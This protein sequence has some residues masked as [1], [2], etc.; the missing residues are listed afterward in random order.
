MN[1]HILQKKKVKKFFEFIKKDTT[2]KVLYTLAM[3]FIF[4]LG[5]NI[6][7]SSVDSTFIEAIGGFEILSLLTGADFTSFSIFALGL[8]P[9][10]TGSI[11]YE[12]LS[13]D[14]ISVFSRWKKE[15]DTNKK[16]IASNSIG[17]A[18]GIIQALSITDMF[19][20]QYGIL[21]AGNI[22]S[23]IYTTG[24]LVAGSCF[25]L[26]ITKMIDIKG[27]GN[28]SSLIIAAGILYNL[29]G[30]ILDAFDVTVTYS[31]WTT[32]IVFGLLM[33]LYLAII[34]YVVFIEKSERHIPIVFSNYSTYV[35]GKKKDYL[36]MKVNVSGVI[37]V[38]FAS[39]VLSVPSII[40]NI[41]GWNPEWINRFSLNNVF[42][43]T[44]YGLLII[45]FTFYYSHTL[46]VP[47]DINRNFQKSG[48]S[49]VSVRLGKD[50]ISYLNR[51]LNRICVFGSVSLLIIALVPVVTPLVWDV[52]AQTNLTIGGTSLII[53]SSTMI[54]IYKKF[55]SESTRAKYVKQTSIWKDR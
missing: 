25:L 30:I 31:N 37:P 50:T 54:T 41:G 17:L 8:S 4:R 11:V 7:V 32:F 43:I 29:P 18:I 36:P 51:I 14:V 28:G 35:S 10:I 22:Y 44:I 21:R 12:L 16:V 53:V 1:L 6:T 20:N 15:N 46:I 34:G 55:K 2:K 47:K 49:I 48:C 24:V 19:D 52:A 42:G 3:L 9:F 33:L 39:S 45:F 26:W 5:N 27:I 13:N 38:I 23:Y 40:C